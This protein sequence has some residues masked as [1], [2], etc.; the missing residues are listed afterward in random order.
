MIQRI[1]KHIGYPQGA[2][3]DESTLQLIDRAIAEVEHASAFQFIYDHYAT[4]LPFMSQHARYMEFLAGAEGYLLC[5][6]TLGIQIDRLLKRYQATDMSYAVI[7][8]AAASVYLECQA[9][10]YQNQLGFSNLGFRFCP[11]Y[12]GTSITDNQSI[13]E[14]LHAERIGITFLE[15]GLMVPQKSMIGI[16]KMGGE[17]RKSCQGCIAAGGCTYR[18]RGVTCW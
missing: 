16:I 14:V 5:A 15:S 6:T 1:L 13:A 9:D 11:G 18:Q 2:N 4:P 17:Q 7:F 8:D 12:G 10:E 3:A